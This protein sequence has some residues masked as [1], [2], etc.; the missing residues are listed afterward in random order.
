MPFS[1]NISTPSDIAL[2][3]F[4]PGFSPGNHTVF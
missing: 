4:D 2:S 3:S 1:S